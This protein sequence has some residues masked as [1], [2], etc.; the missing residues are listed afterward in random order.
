MT[1][2][3]LLLNYDKIC[4]SCGKLFY[5][6]NIRIVCCCKNCAII[7]HKKQQRLASA[8]YRKRQKEKEV[9]K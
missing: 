8:N 4:P 6:K 7:R 9:K 5:S 3:R 1:K 2:H